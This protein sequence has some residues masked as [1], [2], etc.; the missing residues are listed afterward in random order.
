MEINKFN[1]TMKYLT[2]PAERP[3]QSLEDLTVTTDLPE[4]GMEFQSVIEGFGE[5]LDRNERQEFD[6]GGVVEREGF[7]KGSE[8]LPTDIKNFLKESFPKIDF[9]FSASQKYG[10]SKVK[11]KSLFEKIQK[12]ALKKIKNKNYV[13]TPVGTDFENL[14]ENLKYKKGYGTGKQLLAKAKEKGI[15]VSDTTDAVVFAKKFK[16]PVKKSPITTG[17]ALI[18]NLD[19]LNDD[20]FVEKIQR[21]QVRG[22][23]ATPE[24]TEKFLSKDIKKAKKREL[25]QKRYFAE[26]KQGGVQKAFR[27]TKISGVE[28]SH[29]NDLFSQYITGQNVGYVPR[30]I[31]VE[32]GLDEGIDNKMKTL[33]KKRQRLLEQKPKNLKKELE[34]INIKGARLAGQSQGFKTFTI[35]DPVSQKTYEFGGKRFQLDPTNQFPGMTEREIVNFIK[36]ADPDDFDAQLKI[37]MFEDNRKAVFDAVKKQ[38]SKLV[39]EFKKGPRPTQLYSGLAALP[40]MGRIGKEMI[41]QDVPKFGRFAGQVA[42][43]AGKV[44]ATTGRALVGPVELPVSLAAGGVYANYQD[45]VDFEKAVRQTDFSENKKKDLINKFRRSQLDLDVGVGEEILVDTMGTESDIIGGIK[46][47]KQLGQF[48]TI[49]RNAIDAVRRQ[50][51]ADL[52]DERRDAALIEKDELF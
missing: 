5:S 38:S 48:Q 47:P 50:E 24:V 42:K 52:E 32:M 37:K 10:V 13:Y 9:K 36:N 3:G 25:G 45:R 26:K 15:N 34:N 44:V 8:P 33:Y 31:N 41:T 16:I 40:E 2:R 27:G 11:D 46:D 28:K 18:Y 6:E 14:R 22:G 30:E 43:G 4:E 49:A 21:A 1:Q 39:K 20:A 7:R 17:G 12:T 19:I 23:R 51:F 29:M 35:M